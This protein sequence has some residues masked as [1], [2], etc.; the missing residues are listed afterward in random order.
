MRILVPAVGK[1]TPQKIKREIMVQIPFRNQK[2]G[3]STM[4]ARL[5]QSDILGLQTA[6]SHHC[7]FLKINIF[8]VDPAANRSLGCL[9]LVR[10]LEV[11]FQLWISP[12]V[13][14]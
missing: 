4:L 2:N 14:Y 5:D 6:H 10:I 1:G 3:Q 7:V 9:I 11:V 8:V 13:Q 12:Q